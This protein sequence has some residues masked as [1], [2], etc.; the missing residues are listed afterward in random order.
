MTIFCTADEIA[1]AIVTA[2]RLE[3]ENPEEIA[4]GSFGIRARWFAFAALLDELPDNDYRAIA[5]GVGIFNINSMVS[6]RAALASYRRGKAP[7]WWDEGKV[8]RV[9]EALAKFA[10]RPVDQSATPVDVGPDSASVEPSAVD[11]SPEKSVSVADGIAQPAVL[12]LPEDAPLGR[13]APAAPPV[14]PDTDSIPI[15]RRPRMRSS[16]GNVTAFVLGDPA[17]GRSAL[18]QR[19]GGR[20]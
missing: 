14:L 2:A 9:R 19:S 18:A 1:V 8:E 12:C 4:Q 10:G 6:A 5:L 7:K 17:A 3:G 15:S 13:G 20:A 16:R 11:R